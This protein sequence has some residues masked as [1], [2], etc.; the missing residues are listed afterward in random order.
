MLCLPTVAVLI[1]GFFLLAELRDILLRTPVEN[2]QP[3]YRYSLI[4]QLIT[5]VQ[6]QPQQNRHFNLMQK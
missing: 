1:A 3:F 5:M 4:Y 6:G 2:A